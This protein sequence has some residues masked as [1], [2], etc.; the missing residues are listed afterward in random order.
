MFT[1]KVKIRTVLNGCAISGINSGRKRA[2]I[3]TLLCVKVKFGVLYQNAYKNKEMTPKP[4]PPSSPYSCLPP[5]TVRMQ[6][7]REQDLVMSE[8]SPGCVCEWRRR[9]TEPAGLGV[10]SA[11]D[12]GASLGRSC[13]F[14][15]KLQTQRIQSSAVYDPNTLQ[16]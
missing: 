2:V 13:T 11:C 8:Q 7:A 10:C 5:L 12:Y 9:A 6:W 3:S 1:D 4:W 16:H 15:H 14:P